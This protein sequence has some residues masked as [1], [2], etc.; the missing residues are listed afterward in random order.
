MSLVC[1]KGNKCTITVRVKRSNTCNGTLAVSVLRRK[2]RDLRAAGLGPLRVLGGIVE[3]ASSNNDEN[4][5][6]TKQDRNRKL[7]KP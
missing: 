4:K 3:I 1:A 6:V 7:M 5:N 2:G